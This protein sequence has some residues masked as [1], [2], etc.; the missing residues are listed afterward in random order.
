MVQV[1][2]KGGP[3]RPQGKWMLVSGN[4]VGV[5]ET[6]VYIHWNHHKRYFGI[7]RANAS[8]ALRHAVPEAVPHFT[9]AKEDG[10]LLSKVMTKLPTITDDMRHQVLH[11]AFVTADLNKNGTLS[12]PELGTMM[13]RVICYLKQVEIADLMESADAN[14][15]HKIQYKEFVTWMKSS[16]PPNVKAALR[17]SLDKSEDVVKATFRLWDRN[18][19]GLISKRELAGVLRKVCTT[20]KVTKEQLDALVAVMDTDHNGKVDYDEF[21]DFLFGGRR[22]LQKA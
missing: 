4:R 8:V 10:S 2:L 16:A 21:V 19:D 18:G 14:A 9:M 15:D 22:A 7:P 11:A 5:N 13:R 20:V 1:F 6:G 17:Q 3:N 12:R